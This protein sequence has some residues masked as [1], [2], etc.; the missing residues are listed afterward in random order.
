MVCLYVWISAYRSP[1]PDA[2]PLL[3]AYPPLPG[4]NSARKII[5]VRAEWADQ[6]R[7]NIWNPRRP[8]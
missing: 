5:D 3:N 8:A 2:T 6:V 4:S 7:L 1:N